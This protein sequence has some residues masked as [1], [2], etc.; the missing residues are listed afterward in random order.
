MYWIWVS[1]SDWLDS[2]SRM[3]AQT[4]TFINLNIYI[5]GQNTLCV[6][7]SVY[8]STTLHGAMMQKIKEICFHSTFYLI[9]T[10]VATPVN[11]QDGDLFTWYLIKCIFFSFFIL[12]LLWFLQYFC[13]LELIRGFRWRHTS[14]PLTDVTARGIFLCVFLRVTIVDAVFGH[15]GEAF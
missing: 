5:F 3:K 10:H 15:R 6:T 12:T 8:S 2:K 1:F 4:K 13:E 9:L 14:L 11:T 7:T